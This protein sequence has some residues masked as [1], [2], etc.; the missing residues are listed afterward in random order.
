MICMIY[1]YDASYDVNIIE[2]GNGVHREQFY[3]LNTQSFY[4]RVERLQN[5]T[6][7]IFQ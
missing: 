6:A 1:M 7:C 2:K 5:A 4:T 3:F